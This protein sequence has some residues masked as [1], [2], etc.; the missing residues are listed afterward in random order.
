MPE[1]ENVECVAYFKPDFQLSTQWR[2]RKQCSCLS[3][4]CHKHFEGGEKQV[5]KGASTSPSLETHAVGLFIIPRKMPEVEIRP[6]ESDHQKKRVPESILLG[7]RVQSLD[8]DPLRWGPIPRCIFSANL[9]QLSSG[10][11]MNCLSYQC[12]CDLLVFRRVTRSHSWSN[13]KSKISLRFL[14]NFNLAFQRW[15]KPR[16]LVAAR[17]SKTTEIESRVYQT[18][19][20]ERKE[21]LS[22]RES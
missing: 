5:I 1:C 15:Y 8:W 21:S 4:E 17:I 3:S 13:S 16:K 11:E 20:K 18:N 10:V 9:P 12:V 22:S 14:K 19:G 2:D 6:S 7:K